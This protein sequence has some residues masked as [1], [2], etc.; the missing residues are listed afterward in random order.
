MIHSFFTSTLL[1][2][3]LALTPTSSQRT[4][5]DISAG[6]WHELGRGIGE[7][8]LDDRA[9]W[10]VA[11]DA[12]GVIV[13]IGSP[14]HNTIDGVRA[15]RVRVY[16]YDDMYDTWRKIG[17]DI[18]G[19]AGDE[20]GTSIALSVSGEYLAVGAPKC[21]RYE[22]TELKK[23]KGCVRIYELRGD[24]NKRNFEQLGGTIVGSNAFDHFGTAVDLHAVYGEETDL[25]GYNDDKTDFETVQVAIGAPGAKDENRREVGMVFF[26]EY[27]IGDARGWTD[28]S[29]DIRNDDYVG[30]GTPGSR[31]GSSLSLSLDNNLMVVGAPKARNGAG[32]AFLFTREMADGVGELRWSEVKL[33]ATSVTWGEREGEECGTSVSIDLRGDYFIYGCPFASSD[34]QYQAGKVLVKNL[35]F[36]TSTQAYDARLIGTELF[37]EYSGDHFGTAV[38]I[39]QD[40]EFDNVF[41]GVG[42]PNNYPDSESQKAGHIRVYHYVKSEAKWFRAGLDVDGKNAFDELGSSIAISFDGH[43]VVGGA[44]GNTGYAKIYELKYT[45]EPTQAPTRPPSRPTSGNPTVGTG[46]YNNN[47]RI[48]PIW[49]TIFYMLLIGL[50]IYAVAKGFLYYRAR[51]AY[52]SGFEPSNE[53]THANDLELSP[54]VNGPTTADTRDII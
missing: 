39:G 36:N 30:E 49:L 13:A 15:G 53:V 51:S 37:G 20:A 1:L 19:E 41:I 4:P 6:L 14:Y 34:S 42:A 3:F 11:S 16:E 54:N 27:M 2:F 10:S 35:K 7:E 45:A 25:D 52:K 8:N 46:K 21:S 18:E 9:S 44:P 23:E 26:V 24:Y 47:P 5:K 12:E 40:E 28:A 48:R 50:S 22:G 33:G 31:F 38:D 17:D 43:R 29:K 32:E